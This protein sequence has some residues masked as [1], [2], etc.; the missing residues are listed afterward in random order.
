M[1]PRS[2]SW[3]MAPSL[4]PIALVAPHQLY[5]KAHNNP[6]QALGSQ[7]V[8]NRQGERVWHRQRQQ[9]AAE[10]LLVDYGAFPS[11]Y[12]TGRTSPVVRQ[13]TQQSFS[14]PGFSVCRK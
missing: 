11:P 14:G 10:I 8:V 2:S 6:F 1:R 3:T 7:F 4:L 5:D 13:G 9:D 12:C